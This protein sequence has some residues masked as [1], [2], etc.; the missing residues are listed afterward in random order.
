[1]RKIDLSP[2]F[3]TRYG[4]EM[5]IEDHALMLTDNGMHLGR[6]HTTSTVFV[7]KLLQ[8]PEEG[9]IF[10][11]HFDLG[12]GWG[13][14]WFDRDSMLKQ[15]DLANGRRTSI[16]T[17]TAMISTIGA[18]VDLSVSPDACVSLD[19]RYED[20]P[21]PVKWSVNG[22]YDTDIKRFNAGS[23]R[24]ILSFRYFF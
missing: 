11:F 20:V 6:V 5:R 2:H 9:N 3:I 12:M 24:L 17:D 1:M 21:I 10:G 14:T 19:L 18:G 22:V 16:S 23:T 15:D 8:M 13:S 7:F 4:I